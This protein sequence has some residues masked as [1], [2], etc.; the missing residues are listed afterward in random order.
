[1]LRA[2]RSDSRAAARY[3][4]QRVMLAWCRTDH[5]GD[6]SAASL[7]KSDRKTPPAD[8]STAAPAKP[9][10]PGASSDDRD[11]QIT[12]RRSHR[13]ARRTRAG[14]GAPLPPGPQHTGHMADTD[15]TL[16]RPHRRWPACAA[17]PHRHGALGRVGEAPRR[18]IAASSRQG[19]GGTVAAADQSHVD[20]RPAAHHEP[21]A[22][23]SQAMATR[24]NDVDPHVIAAPGRTAAPTSPAPHRR[25]ALSTSAADEDR[26]RRDW[27]GLT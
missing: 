6:H 4:P 15:A 16:P 20:V 26:S 24:S 3:P 19:V 8:Q 18:P 17:P 13:A 12:P 21:G 7:T 1:M 2:R 9:S 5:E 22:G 27:R 11:E 23:A 25:G 10:A 14:G